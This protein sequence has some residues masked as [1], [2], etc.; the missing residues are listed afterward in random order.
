MDSF[1]KVVARVLKK[2]IKE[3]DKSGDRCPE[4]KEKAM[5]Y[6]EGCCLCLSCGYTAC[7]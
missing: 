1:N 4:C 3:G 2:Y 5:I 6:Q 7:S